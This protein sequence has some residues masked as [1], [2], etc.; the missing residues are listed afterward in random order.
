M[1]AVLNDRQLTEEI[2]LT[3]LCLVEQLLNARP[4][5]AVSS[6]VNDFEALFPNH[7]LLGCSTVYF[8]IGSVR[9]NDRSHRRVFCQAQ[10]YTELVWRRWPNEHV[11]QLQTR[12]KWLSDSTVPVSIDSLVCLV[13]SSSAKGQNLLGRVVKLNKAVDGIVRSATIKTS[14]GLF[15]RPVVKLVSLL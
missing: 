6:D 8:P 4:L 10:Y 12:S 1:L 11:P 15:T 9:T 13:D 3:T 7:I 14:S 2:L 5:T